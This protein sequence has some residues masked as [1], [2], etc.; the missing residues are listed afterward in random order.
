ME[1]MSTATVC[2]APRVVTTFSSPA[3]QALRTIPT[4]VAE[5]RVARKILCA[6]SS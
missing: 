2:I 1:Y 5:L 6:A 4:G 3:R